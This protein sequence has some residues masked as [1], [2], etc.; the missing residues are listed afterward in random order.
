MDELGTEERA[1]RLIPSANRASSPTSTL[2]RARNGEASPF[3]SGFLRPHGFGW[4]VGTSIRS[5]AG[6]LLVFTSERQWDK[7]PV[8]RAAVDGLDAPAPTFGA[9]AVLSARMGLERARTT[10][11]AL[12]TIGLP[13]G[14]SDHERPRGRGQSGLRGQRSAHRPS[15]QATRWRFRR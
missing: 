9:A 11:I 6:D 7:G 4:C 8:E 14:G 3:C 1:E 13:A 5:T 15:Q 12:Q 10:V 2:S